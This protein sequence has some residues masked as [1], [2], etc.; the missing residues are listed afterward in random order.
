MAIK[1]PKIT[2]KQD[3]D[4]LLIRSPV[5]NDFADYFWN[6]PNDAKR[7]E[8]HLKKQKNPV[9]KKVIKINKERKKRYDRLVKLINKDFNAIN[10]SNL[11]NN[12]KRQFR[13]KI[14]KEMSRTAPDGGLSLNAII[15]ASDIINAIR[16]IA[17]QRN[18]KISL[19]RNSTYNKLI[20][21]LRSIRNNEITIEERR[22]ISQL[23]FKKKVN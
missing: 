5:E 16:N 22:L 7:Y 2:I 20:N 23:I 4:Y 13:I 14:N 15:F 6:F 21:S 11:S 3:L 12:I 17:K 19:T 9:F 10:R 18:V 8:N 1:Q